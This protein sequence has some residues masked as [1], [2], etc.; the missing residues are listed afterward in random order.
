M[1]RFVREKLREI[2]DSCYIDSVMSCEDLKRRENHISI[3][4]PQMAVNK[5]QKFIEEMKVG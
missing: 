3:F 5:I 4:C 2:I 1:N